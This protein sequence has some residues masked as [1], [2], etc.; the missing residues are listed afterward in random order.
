SAGSG[1]PAARAP[2]VSRP[3]MRTVQGD[4]GLRSSAAGVLAADRGWLARQFPAPAFGPGWLAA[5]CAR[6]A[7]QPAAVF[8]YGPDQRLD[9]V[10][11][12]SCLARAI[13]RHAGARVVRPGPG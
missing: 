3:V 8:G 5:A 7:A 9:A 12:I 4:L 10:L 2:L 11:T 13:E 6:R 1:P